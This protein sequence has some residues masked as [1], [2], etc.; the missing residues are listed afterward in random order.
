MPPTR[1]HQ[2]RSAIAEVLN[3][4]EGWLYPESRLFDN[5]NLVMVRPPA[6]LAEFEEVIARMEIA[7][8]LIRF[9]TQDEGIKSKLSDEGKAELLK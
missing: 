4:T 3:Q 2:I 9:R 5:I 7:R 6:T 1:R 8:Q